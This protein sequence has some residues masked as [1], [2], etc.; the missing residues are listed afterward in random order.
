MARIP[1]GG[2][3]TVDQLGK[4]ATPGASAVLYLTRLGG[5]PI[6]DVIDEAGAAIPGGIITIPADGIFPLVRP[7]SRRADG[8]MGERERWPASMAAGAQ[9]GGRRRDCHCGFGADPL[10]PVGTRGAADP[11]SGRRGDDTYRRHGR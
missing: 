6:A 4:V 2:T 8:R 3:A 1:V 9:L 7:G 5:T 11:E 10:H